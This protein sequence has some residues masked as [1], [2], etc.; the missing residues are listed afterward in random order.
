MALERN[1]GE[2]RGTRVTETGIALVHAGEVILPA[3]TDARTRAP[4]VRRTTVEKA[5]VDPLVTVLRT[6]HR[7]CPARWVSIATS[8]PWMLETPLSRT[9]RPYATEP[10][11]ELSETRPENSTSTL[12]G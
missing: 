10:L 2:D 12:P 8:V 3:A 7:V 9:V 4:R 11:L 5:P 6:C 1:D